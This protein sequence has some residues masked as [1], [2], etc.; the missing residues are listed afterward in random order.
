MDKIW[1]A[2]VKWRDGDVE[3][4]GPFAKYDEGIKVWSANFSADKRGEFLWINYHL[5][6]QN[7]QNG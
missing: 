2:E 6:N 3:L 4:F 1:I 5:L 7:I